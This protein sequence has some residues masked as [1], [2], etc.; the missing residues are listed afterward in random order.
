MHHF[1]S[2]TLNFFWKK[3]YVTLFIGLFLIVLTQRVWNERQ[4]GL[5]DSVA[6]DG[7]SYY[8]YLP[9]AIIYHDFK[10][11]FY[12]VPETH[13]KAVHHTYF[14]EYKDTRINKYYYGTAV[15]FLGFHKRSRGSCELWQR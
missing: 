9:A 3:K 11:K 12:S 13:I 1:F 5:T 7:L 4:H 6:S 14:N 8:S 10:Y 2:N 15:C